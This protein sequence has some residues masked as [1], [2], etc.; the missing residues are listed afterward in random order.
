M[1]AE[2]AA[3]NAAFAVIKTAVQNGGDLLAA[4]QSLGQYFTAKTEL[5]KKVNDKSGKGHDR[6][7]LEEFLALQQLKEREAE[8]KQLMIYSGRAGLWTEWLEYQSAQKQKR[9]DAERKA[10][11][12]AARRKKKL[13]DWTIG[14][15]LAVALLSGL[16]LI[17][18]IF[19]YISRN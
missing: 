5:Q 6:S 13:V 12:D 14:T 3:A 7:D 16:G 19:Y 9:L 10:K 2:L 8:L 15:L 1:I 17:G 11:A 18:Y 4:G